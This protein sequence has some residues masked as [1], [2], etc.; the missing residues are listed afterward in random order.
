MLIFTPT[1]RCEKQNKK[2][3]LLDKDRK[4]EYEDNIP[5]G[6]EVDSEAVVNLFIE[7]FW[8]ECVERCS[9]LYQ[10]EY[11]SPGGEGLVSSDPTG[12]L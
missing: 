8:R 4:F 2:S 10:G 9:D 1:H 5:E 11:R 6:S 7:L 12:D 3:P